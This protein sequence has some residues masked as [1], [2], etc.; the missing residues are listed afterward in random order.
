MAIFA[1]DSEYHRKAFYQIGDVVIYPD[2]S[3]AEIVLVKRGQKVNG[4][5]MAYPS[6]SKDGWVLPS[7]SRYLD[8]NIGV[9]ASDDCIVAIRTS[10]PRSKSSRRIGRLGDLKPG[11]V[12]R[13][14]SGVFSKFTYYVEPRSQMMPTMVG[15]EKPQSG[16][17]HDDNMI[18]EIL[19]EQESHEK[20]LF[21]GRTFL[22]CFDAFV[23]AQQNEG[24]AIFD[25]GRMIKGRARPEG[26]FTVACVVLDEEQLKAA[27]QEWSKQLRQKVNE[28]EEKERLRIVCD[29]SFEE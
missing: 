23:E 20:K 5:W 7:Q 6:T 2:G 1:Y 22:Q 18:V 8:I 17:K 27:R 3:E 11:T 26:G 25:G 29:S 9:E 21:G 19:W 10:D 24:V 14:V 16:K 12:Y 28:S 15:G 4:F 13:P